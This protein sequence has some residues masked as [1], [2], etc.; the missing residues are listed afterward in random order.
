VLP[1]DK[2]HPHDYLSCP[3]V[4]PGEKARRRDPRTHQALTCPGTKRSGRCSRGVNCPYAHGVFEL[5]LHPARY[6]T[7]L[8]TDGTSCTRRVCFF[9]HT[10]EQL[11]APTSAAEALEGSTLALGLPPCAGLAGGAADLGSGSG[12][13]GSTTSSSSS[14]VDDRCCCSSNSCGSDSASPRL[15]DSLPRQPA[16][17]RPGAAPAASPSRSSAGSSPGFWHPGFDPRAGLC[18]PQQQQQ[19]QQRGSPQ[20][21]QQQLAGNLS[22]G[23]LHGAAP[24]AGTWKQQAPQ[25]QARQQAA[26]GSSRQLEQLTALVQQVLLRERAPAAAP[27]PGVQELLLAALAQ[28]LQPQQ[29]PQPQQQLDTTG[30]LSQLIGQLLVQQQQQQQQLP[31]ASLPPPAFGSPAAML[32]QLGLPGAWQPLPQSDA[33]AAPFGMHRGAP[34]PAPAWPPS[35]SGGFGLPAAARPAGVQLP[36]AFLGS[37]SDG[38]CFGSGPTDSGLSSG[39]LQQCSNPWLMQGQ[40]PDLGGSLGGLQQHPQRMVPLAPAQQPGLAWL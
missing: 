27:A 18:L 3:Y 25:Q 20:L 37:A 33:A 30:L 22:L 36:G 9:A 19:P 40:L 6:R 26:A 17:A 16:L 23:M 14:V 34:A 1:C 7:Q 2:R 10:P 5:W 21:A 15:L 39:L 8:C 35:S 11:R 28:Q 12:D 29:Q 4:H 32:Q 31:Q 13:C 38:I 24:A